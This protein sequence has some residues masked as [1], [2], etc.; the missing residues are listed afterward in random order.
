[1]WFVK[2]V[3][4]PVS[5][6]VEIWALKGCWNKLGLHVILLGAFIFLSTADHKKDPSSKTFTF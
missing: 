4:P 6:G 5:E 2:E 1:M 3:K